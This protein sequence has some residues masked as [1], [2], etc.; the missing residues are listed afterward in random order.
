[1]ERRWAMGKAVKVGEL[2]RKNPESLGNVNE[3]M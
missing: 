2:L 3:K 1:M